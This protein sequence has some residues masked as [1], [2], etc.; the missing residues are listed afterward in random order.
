MILKIADPTAENKWWFYDG[1]EKISVDKEAYVLESDGRIV[2]K[3]DQ[4]VE[5]IAPD[6]IL[7]GESNDMDII[8]CIIRFSRWH[9]DEFFVAFQGE[10]YLLNDDGKTIEA[11]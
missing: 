11:L 8:V 2:R 1:I 9:D 5:L 3:E 6:V 7:C 10:A 4:N